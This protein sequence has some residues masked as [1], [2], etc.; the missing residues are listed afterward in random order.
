M[1]SK[2]E[3]K[4][5]KLS[6]ILISIFIVVSITSAVYQKYRLNGIVNQQEILNNQQK[7]I[8]ELQRKIIEKQKSILDMYE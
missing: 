7:E 3:Q 5:S 6:I 1:K 2:E 8:N 4:I